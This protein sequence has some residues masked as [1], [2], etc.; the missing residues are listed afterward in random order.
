[1]P[2]G[3][4]RS[5]RFLRLS[6]L[7]YSSFSEKFQV[8]NN[9]KRYGPPPDEL[10]EPVVIPYCSGRIAP[11]RGNHFFAE[12]VE[13][14]IYRIAA[15]SFLNTVPLIDWFER[16][17]DERVALTRALPS[18]LGGMLSA[19]EA[20]VA[21]LPVVEIFRGAGAGMLAA[22][23]IACRGRVDSVKLFHHGDPGALPKVAGGPRI[24]HLGGPAGDPAEG[25][26]RHRSC[27]LTEFE[28]PAAG[29]L[30]RARAH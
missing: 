14:M 5:V 4:V 28:P 27:K 15:V 3:R 9:F 12:C 2:S 19:G 16:T 18:R 17:G 10:D 7:I 22:T 26:V 6:A 20:D 24:P 29:A 23:G 30:H 13:L 1:M 8:L 25:T 11:R 21:L